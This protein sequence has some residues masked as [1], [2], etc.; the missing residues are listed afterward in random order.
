MLATRR[1]QAGESLDEFLNVLKRLSKDCNFKAVSAENYQKEMIR[2]AFINGLLSQHIRQKLLENTTLDLDAAYRQARSLES[3]QRNSDVYSTQGT[4]SLN[5]VASPPNVSSI[6]NTPAVIAVNKNRK[7]YFCGNNIH[8]R[9]NCPARDYTC[10]KCGKTGHFPK[11]CQSN[12]KSSQAASAS[13]V[14]D[15]LP[16]ASTASVYYPTLATI[17]AASPQGL[18]KAVVKTEVNEHSVEALIAWIVS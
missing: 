5:T 15:T 1:Q 8:N 4:H 13:P 14:A 12:S 10:N 16:S 7:C 2:D 11:V 6:F 17:S 3:A 9:Q 18:Q